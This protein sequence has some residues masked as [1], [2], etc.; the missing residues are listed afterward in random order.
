MAYNRLYFI[1]FFVPFIRIIAF[2]VR[3]KIGHSSILFPFT[4][5]S[6]LYTELLVA[7]LP[8]HC[9]FMETL[10]S[11]GQKNSFN[12]FGL[13]F[14]YIL[15]SLGLLCTSY[16]V[17]LIPFFRPNSCTNLYSYIQVFQF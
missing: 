15:H 5:Y 1:D 9:F 4:E 16:K 3:Y 10:Q 13:H 8:Y 12:V 17:V 11:N 6:L 2:P 7:F 14:L